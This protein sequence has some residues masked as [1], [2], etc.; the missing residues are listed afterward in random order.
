ATPEPGQGTHR[1]SSLVNGGGQ[2]RRAAGRVGVDGLSQGLARLE[3]GHQLLRDQH[4]FARARIAALAG[5]SAVDGETAETADFNAM[6]T[7]EGF[8]HAVQDGLD[9]ELRVT[10]GE[11]SKTLGE[12]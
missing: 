3:M 6:P 4:L 2:D 10:L 12:T 7:R 11:L 8:G 1:A 9:G 5:R